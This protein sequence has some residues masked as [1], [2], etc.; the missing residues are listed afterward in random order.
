MVPPVS[1]GIMK[2]KKWIIAYPNIPFDLCPV[3]HG[4][5]ISVPEPSKEFTTNHTSPTVGMYSSPQP[6]IL[7][8][9][10]LNYLVHD[11]ELSKSKAELLGSRLKQQNLLE[12]N[13]RILFPS[14]HQQLVP[15]FRKED[16]L[17]FC[18]DV[19]GMIKSLGIKHDP[20]I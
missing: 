1:G 18:Y 20:Q 10:K 6:H 5:G 4:E 7:T 16:E 17:V 9:D 2:K 15:F 13:V 3:S 8:Q 11:L 14:R 12:K 19:D